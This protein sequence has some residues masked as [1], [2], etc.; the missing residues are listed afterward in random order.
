MANLWPL[1]WPSSQWIPGELEAKRP[2]QGATGCE[3]IPFHSVNTMS[4]PVY[5][6]CTAMPSGL[7]YSRMDP[8]ASDQQRRADIARRLRERRKELG[9][10]QEALAAQAAVSKS[11]MSELE[12][13]ESIANGLIYLR[14]ANALDVAVQWLLAGETPPAPPE[15]VDPL[16][17]VPQVSALADQH[18]WTHR[19]A[20][21][22]ATALARVVARRS[23]AGKRW[24]PTPEYVLRLAD[25][26]ASGDDS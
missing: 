17:L 7:A 10:T 19:K 12:S 3:A 8:D 16:R 15:T 9:L 2:S 18:G 22:V 11:F 4:S 20:L 25:A 14:L 26:I 6:S 21:D 24:E 5:R 13:G 1:N 23:V